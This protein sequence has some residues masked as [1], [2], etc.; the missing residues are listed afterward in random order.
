MAVVLT[1]GRRNRTVPPQPDHELI[2]VLLEVGFRQVGGLAAR[3]HVQR[4]GPRFLD[5]AGQKKGLG[6][7]R[8]AGQRRVNLPQRFRRQAERKLARVP[9]LDPVREDVR[10]DAGG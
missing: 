9:D 2:A 7:Q 3:N 1:A 5:E 6:Y 8:I 10:L 4:A